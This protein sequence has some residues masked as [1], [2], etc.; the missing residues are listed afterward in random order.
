VEA[1]ETGIGER[2]G[3]FLWHDWVQVGNDVFILEENNIFSAKI[4]TY[5]VIF[6]I[7]YVFIQELATL[8]SPH[9]QEHTPV[10][11]HINP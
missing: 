11:G 5:D 7:S 4:N 10:I 9:N 6:H 3:V 8:I 2:K 1:Q